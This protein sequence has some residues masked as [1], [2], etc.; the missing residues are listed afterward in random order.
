MAV[1]EGRGLGVDPAVDHR[2]RLVCKRVGCSGFSVDLQVEDGR[3]VVSL[4]SGSWI[5]AANLEVNF[6]VVLDIVLAT[7]KLLLFFWALIITP[8]SKDPSPSCSHERNLLM[9]VD[10]VLAKSSAAAGPA[11]RSALA[12]TSSSSS[13]IITLLFGGTLVLGV[14]RYLRV[15]VPPMRKLTGCVPVEVRPWA[16]AAAGGPRLSS[17]A[18]SSAPAAGT[19]GLDR[20]GLKGRPVMEAGAPTFSAFHSRPTHRVVRTR[21]SAARAT[22]L[23][24]ALCPAAPGAGLK[25]LQ[26]PRHR[27]SPGRRRIVM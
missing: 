11:K 17:R 2:V 24:Q 23:P 21:G 10:T 25:I 22:P 13:S 5:F 20:V 3:L 27:G 14:V 15:I 9:S 19:M 6:F 1:V 18:Q 12:T 4:Y 8:S 16:P 7:S 26:N